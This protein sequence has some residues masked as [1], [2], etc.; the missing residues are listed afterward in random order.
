MRTTGTGGFPI[1]FRRGWSDWQKDTEGMISW[2]KANEFGAVDVGADAEACAAVAN[3]GLRI[4]SADLKSWSGIATPDEVK[5]KSFVEE[6]DAYIAEAVKTGATNF[7]A[8]ILPEDAALSRAENHGYAVEGLTAL[9]PVLEKHGAKLVL[10]GWPGAG[11]LACTPETYRSLV[12]RA[13]SPSIGINYD[14]SHL[15][16]MGI[17]PVRFLKE[18]GER[19]Y[20]VHGKDTEFDR[21]AVY[22]YGTEQ[23]PALGAVHGF[24][25]GFW[26]Y[27]IP[28][29]GETPWTSVLSL[30]QGFGYGGAVCIE[31]EDERY[32]GT[33]EG[34]KSGLLTGAAALQSA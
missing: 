4:G 20:H 33:E 27:T 30:L 23:K 11:A 14:P 22:E 5:R 13:E 18:F 21:E 24:G 3:A 32:N 17:D 25:S 34:E 29:H 19:V 1:G 9:A 8:V 28:G 15:I 12:K 10:E 2:A 31:L 16:R 26:R 6:N 7:F